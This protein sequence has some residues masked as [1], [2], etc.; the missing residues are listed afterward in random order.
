MVQSLPPGKLGLPVIGE[1]IAFFTDREFAIK[2]HERYG[3]VFKTNL[4]GQTTV[5]LQGADG[6]RFILTNETKYFQISWPPSVEQLLGPLSLALQSGHTH[7]SRRKILAQAFQ[8]RAL[9]GYVEAMNVISDRYLDR[10][11]QQETL[12]WYPELRDYTLDIACK[13][14][15]GLDDGAAMPLGHYY[16]D[17][18]T[19]LF[20]IPL[21]LPWTAFGKAFRSREKL[22]VE[23]E[24]LIRDRQ[25]QATPVAKNDALDL[26]LSARDDDGEGL[27]LEE[28]KDQILVLLFAG[29]ETLT[30]ALSA[31]CLLLAQHPQVLAR[32]RQ[33]QQDLA[34]QPLNLETLKQMLYLDQILKEVLRVIPPVGGGFRSVIQDCEY[35]G[36]QIQ[37]GWQSLYQINATHLDPTLYPNPQEFDP[38]RFDADRAED[39]QKPFAHVPFGGG[40]R[41]CIGKEFARL[42]IKLFAARLLREYQWELLP[43]Q[44]LDLVV[45]PTPKPKDGLKV[46]F[47]K[48][49]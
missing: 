45:I 4:F 32:A 40:L 49:Q 25:A 15:I 9:A 34:D 16:E 19:G 28:L 33:E 7:V 41:E 20:S 46:R 21:N 1:T 14:L 2:R 6:N 48:L 35:Q 10:W 22:L 30:S 8:P 17:W 39:K 36:Y 42:E 26:M 12:T 27:S 18:S 44:D 31:L 38:D 43:D 29:H 5:F 47:S 37:K 3:P 11:V 13:L 23:I 24:Q